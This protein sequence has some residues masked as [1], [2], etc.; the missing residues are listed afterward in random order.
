M[1]PGKNVKI[2]REH[3]PYGRVLIVDDVDFNL[4]LTEGLLKPYG[5]TIETVTNGNDAI[6]NIR[7]GNTY[8]IIFM[9]QVM[10]EM[11]GA[12][13]T[14]RIREEGYTRPII[15]LSANVTYGQ[16]DKF[17]ESGHDDSISKPLNVRQLN[18]ILNKW[19]RDKQTTG[20]QNG[21]PDGVLPDT[22]E[23]TADDTDE[24]S[25]ENTSTIAKLREIKSLDVD[26]ALEAV[27]G[28]E[29]VFVD[30]VKLMSRR[31]P[32]NI[33]KLENSLSAGDTK[34]FINTVHGLISVLKGIGAFSLGNEAAKLEHA[35]LSEDIVFCKEFFP[36]F[37]ESLFSLSTSLVTALPE[38]S[39]S[40]KKSGDK[41][42]LKQILADVKNATEDFNMNLALELIAPCMDF[43]Y[44][45]DTDSILEKILF[46]LEEFDYEGVI[47]AIDKF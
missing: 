35:G 25:A 5:L 18:D 37:K 30:S 28:L 20:I 3:M 23:H 21:V 7:S 26:S 31:L 17:L 34:A 12:E 19:I 6:E 4:F 42:S 45:E 39:S 1:K 22:V 33:K 13:T 32:D 9:D 29:Y 11:D 43:T 27:S 36:S 38:K 24:I 2:V 14:K 10:P 46:N 8:D 16:S 41:S 44:D 15:A 47:D 40:V